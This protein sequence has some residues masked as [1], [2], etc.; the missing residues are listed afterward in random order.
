[1]PNTES[2]ILMGEF[3]AHVGVDAEKWNGVIGKDGPSDLNNN[4]M[5]LLRDDRGGHDSGDYGLDMTILIHI[6]TIG[7]IINMFIIMSIIVQKKMNSFSFPFIYWSQTKEFVA[8]RVDVCDARG[9]EVKFTNES[10]EFTSSGNGENENHRYHFN[11]KLYD[12]V[13]DDKQRIDEMID[14]LGLD[15]DSGKSYYEKG[16]SS[17]KYY[18]M[19]YNNAMFIGYFIIFIRLIIGILNKGKDFLPEVWRDVGFCMICC[20]LGQFL[21][22]GHA[23]LGYVRSSWFAT[24]LQVR[25]CFMRD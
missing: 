8:I 19:T 13:D 12:S 9:V 5:K 21:E 14:K 16:I 17:R 22:I 20:Q 3:N 2:L 10:V 23:L 11:I 1:M 6:F 24:S 15:R 7:N 4:G 25:F 18:L